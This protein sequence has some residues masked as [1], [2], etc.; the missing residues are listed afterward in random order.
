MSLYK[1]TLLQ[2]GVLPSA[3][4]RLSNLDYTVL[5]TNSDNRMNIRTALQVVG[6]APTLGEWN[7]A[8]LDA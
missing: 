4:S 7:G 1:A 5:Y 3:Q 2:A 8:D 6:V